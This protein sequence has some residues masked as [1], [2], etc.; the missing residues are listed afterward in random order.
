VKDNYAYGAIGDISDGLQETP[1]VMFNA[2]CPGEPNIP[3]DSIYDLW[4]SVFPGRT[5]PVVIR[6]PNGSQSFSDLGHSI[7]SQMQSIFSD[8]VLNFKGSEVGMYALV[9]PS[10]SGGLL[11]VNGTGLVLAC[12]WQA[13]PKLVSVQTVNFTAQS[14]GSQDS[15]TVPQ[16]TGRAVLLTLQGMAQAVHFGS[17]IDINDF[18]QTWTIRFIPTVASMVVQTL[19]ADGGKAA[20][21]RFNDYFSSHHKDLAGFSVCNNNNR[22]VKPHWRFGN[23][24]NL[25]WIAI[26][27][28]AGMGF[29]AIVSVMWFTRRPRIW[30]IKPL[31][32]AHAFLLGRVVT[33]DGIREG[34]QVLSIREVRLG[35]ANTMQAASIS[36]SRTI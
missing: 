31:E 25:G 14:L 12:V 32:V 4:G 3:A 24:Y 36:R 11:M 8:P 7:P 6:F 22:T 30:G 17:N 26:I 23:Q 2:Y 18:P 15:K 29:L 5:P 19:L 34:R 20:L 35:K 10:G 9:N 21:T 33:E 27:L 16:L 13:T 28:T 1:G